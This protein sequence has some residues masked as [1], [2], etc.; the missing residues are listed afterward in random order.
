MYVATYATMALNYR[1]LINCCGFFRLDNFVRRSYRTRFCTFA[2]TYSIRR[3]GQI[4]Q[5]K[6]PAESIKLQN[7]V[8]VNIQRSSDRA[9][10]QTFLFYEY[11][12]TDIP[13]REMIPI[14]LIKRENKKYL[15]W[16]SMLFVYCMLFLD[17]LTHSEYAHKQNY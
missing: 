12:H 3:R 2:F 15:I 1:S 17:S 6:N 7:Q 8:E 13:R 10:L 4:I 9:T 14:S 5:N 16:D 11:E